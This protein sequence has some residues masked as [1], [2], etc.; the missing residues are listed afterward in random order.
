MGY[1][2]NHICMET[3][4]L[5]IPVLMFYLMHKDKNL[6]LR[7]YVGQDCIKRTEKGFESKGEKSIIIDDVHFRGATLKVKIPEGLF[8][9][10][11][12]INQMAVSVVSHND[13]KVFLIKDFD[14]ELFRENTGF[15][16]AYQIEFGVEYQDPSTCLI[17]ELL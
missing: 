12:Y 1:F 4:D 9:K 11:E 3:S 10:V 2:N 6:K 13:E 16:I 17:K 14:K 5:Y 7:A 8:S 15:D